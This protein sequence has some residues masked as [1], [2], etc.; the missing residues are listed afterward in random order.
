MGAA[1]QADNSAVGS[2]PA[3]GVPWLYPGRGKVKR[4]KALRRLR[5]RDFTRLPK[6]A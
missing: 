4:R 3:L 5:L 1:A 2:A 6:T